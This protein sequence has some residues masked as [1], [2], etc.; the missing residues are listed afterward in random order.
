MEGLSHFTRKLFSFKVVTGNPCAKVVIVEACLLMAA[1][2]A[3][4]VREIGLGG[5]IKE[6]AIGWISDVES[7]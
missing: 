3:L 6:S 1:L 2:E 7:A 4:A 5:I